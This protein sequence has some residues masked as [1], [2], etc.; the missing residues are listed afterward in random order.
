MVQHFFLQFGLLQLQTT[1]IV[2]MKYYVT[3]DTEGYM[4]SMSNSV[5]AQEN[6]EFFEIDE[7]LSRKNIILDNGVVREATEEEINIREQKLYVNGYALHVRNQRDLL[8]ADSD[9]FVGADRWAKYTTTQKGNITAYRQ[10]L[11]DLPLQ[12]GFP[13]QVVFPELKL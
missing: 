11:R 10:A 8:L 6:L 1:E 3:F 9:K 7:D 4:V 2:N 12:K 5:P 13:E